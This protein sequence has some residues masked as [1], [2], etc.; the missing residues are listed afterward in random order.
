MPNDD[1]AL[2]N[3]NRWYKLDNAAKIYPAVTNANRASVY[4]MSVELMK[5]VNPKVL[6]TALTLT[7]RRFPTFDVRMQRGLF[8]Y[9]FEHNPG[10]ATVSEELAPICRPVNLRETN[11]YL[12][13]VT[14]YHARISLEV[15]HALSDGTGAITFLK[16]LVYH[17]LTLTGRRIVPDESIVAGER[18]L[19]HSEIEDSFQKYYDQKAIGSRAEEVAYQV[20]GTRIPPQNLR[21]TQGIIP[22][23]AFKQLAKDAGATITE[24]T[25]AL[26]IDA[27]FET[28]LKGRGH[29]HPVKVSI[30]INLRKHFPSTTMR[31]F[32]S[33]VNVGMTF[34]AGPYAFEEILASV[35][36][37][38]QDGI[39]KDK[40]IER[41]GANV[42]AE[43]SPF[44]R[45]TPLFLKNIA[46]KTAY[47]LYGER[48]VTS[49]LSNIGVVTIPES[50]KADIRRF[51]FILGAPVMNAFSCA[52]CSFDGSMIVSF[53]RVM[54]EADI[55]R[56][57]FRFLAA[58][59]LQIVIESNNGDGL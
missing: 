25:A 53:S 37:Q 46:L 45:L 59:G 19:S 3:E 14:Y 22:L 57:F 35:K 51:N 12:F 26:I 44:M 32:T 48:L 2:K 24:Y 41:F 49:V 15:F 23:N 9:Y 36:A 58:R 40:L 16:T 8:W 30:P 34:G 27:V 18:C 31:N 10:S 43:R 20:K 54:E 6:Q 39:K 33:Y 5:N 4:R 1:K 7:L 28:Q 47:T 50:M 17:Y 13:R 38:M 42:S 29:K 21:V 52:V 55:E 11:G 56:F